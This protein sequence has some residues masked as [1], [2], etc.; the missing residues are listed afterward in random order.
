MIYR[1]K[2]CKGLLYEED[3]GFNCPMCKRS[4]KTTKA[5]EARKIPNHSLARTDALGGDAWVK[6]TELEFPL[7][8]EKG[9]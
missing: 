6:D 7:D 5:L 3:G 1:C 8:Y 9:E 4:I 2:E